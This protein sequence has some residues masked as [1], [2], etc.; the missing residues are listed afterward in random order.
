L[1]L[2]LKVQ[3]EMRHCERG[4]AIYSLTTDC[5]I[6]CATSQWRNYFSEWPH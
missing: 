5:F 6:W 1:S 2:L 3:N 4:E